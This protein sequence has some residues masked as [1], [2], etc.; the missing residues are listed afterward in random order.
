M[1]EDFSEFNLLDV[2]DESFLAENEEIICRHCNLIS[3]VEFMS[4]EEYEVIDFSNYN[5]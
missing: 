2:D 5:F 3:Y 4:P 1:D